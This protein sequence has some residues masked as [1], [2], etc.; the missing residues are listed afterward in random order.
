[1]E[2]PSGITLK[3]F[4]IIALANVKIPK[5]KA[6]KTAIRNSFQ[7]ILNHSFTVICPRAKAL[8]LLQ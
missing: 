7:I 6:N 3:E 8:V 2:K 1:M 4:N 5:I